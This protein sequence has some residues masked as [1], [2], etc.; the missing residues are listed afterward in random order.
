M[1]KIIFIFLLIISIYLSS[2]TII[3]YPHDH[4]YVDGICECGHIDP[5]YVLPHEHIYINGICECGKTDEE[6]FE[7]INI[8]FQKESYS[9]QTTV[10]KGSI[11]TKELLPIE[12]HD[13][14]VIFY[15]DKE[16]TNRYNFEPLKT[17]T[18]LY[19]T[20]IDTS[21]VDEISLNKTIFDNI[22]YLSFSHGTSFTSFHHMLDETDA[23][24][25]FNKYFLNT[26]L[27]SN[28]DVI[29]YI[30]RHLNSNQDYY[31]LSFINYANDKLLIEVLDCGFVIVTINDIEYASLT[32]IGI[33]K[34]KFIN[35]IIEI[36]NKYYNK[37]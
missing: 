36:E 18:K 10:F 1:K 15:Y 4:V 3:S 9:Y 25:I 16:Y 8:D 28:Q 34:D 6:Y 26:K 32:Y 29:T 22:L 17:D 13:D 30:K 14:I 7:Q 11:I 31:N 12:Y 24:N 19:V 23:I 33:D 5:N 2:C 20:N 21:S 35:E 37:K 27:T